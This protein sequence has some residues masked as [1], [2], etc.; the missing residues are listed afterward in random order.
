[1]AGKIFERVSLRKPRYSGFDLSHEKKLSGKM[2]NLIPV[3]VQEVLPGDSFKVSTE[4]MIR[5]APMLAPVMHRMNVFVHYFFVPNRLLLL[6]GVWEDFITGGQ[7]G[8]PTTTQLPNINLDADAGHRARGTLADYLGIPTEE[9]AAATGDILP[10]TVLPFRAYQSI[11]NEYFRD[12][13]L[14]GVLDIPNLSVA[15]SVALRTR[16]WEK[17]YF[18]SALPWPQ[19]GDDVL[20]PMEI[21]GDTI[22][23]AGDVVPLAPGNVEFDTGGQLEDAAGTDLELV[24]ENASLTVNALRT[25]TAIQRWLEKSA[26]GGYRYVETILAHF[27]VKSSDARLQ[28]PEYLGGGRNPVIISEVLNT[29]GTASAPQGDMTGHGIAA[30]KI[31]NFSRRFEEHGFVMGIMSV[32]PRA[33][34]MQGLPKMFQRGLPVTGSL[35]ATKLRLDFYWPEFANLGEQEIL[36]QELFYDPD[37]DVYNAS[38]FGYQQRYAEYKYM[39]DSVHGDFRDSLDYWHLARKFSSQPVLNTGFVSASP[40]VIGD[41]IF[42]VQ[43]GSDHLWCQVYNSVRARRPMPY[44]SDPRLA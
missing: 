29:T 41:R 20:V 44:F 32:L 12:P 33:A 36:N 25:V 22:R 15:D 37:D 6:P 42:A 31:N 8:T 30:G 9:A 34:Y 21:R 13:N 26:R 19:R 35:D 17:D 3:Y 18:T 24:S 38:A 43:D 2:G 39:C 23:E 40:G 14:D 4:V 1:M 10:V 5:F 11:F 16:R 7:S 27:G 28:R